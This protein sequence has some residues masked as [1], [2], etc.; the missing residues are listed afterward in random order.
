M[1]GDAEGKTSAESLWQLT[2]AC[3]EEKAFVENVDGSVQG[4]FYRPLLKVAKRYRLYGKIH[5]WLPLAYMKYLLRR[6]RIPILS[7]DL[8]RATNNKFTGGHLVVVLSYNGPTDTFQIHDTSSVLAPSGDAL[9]LKASTLKFISN[10]R[11]LSF[12]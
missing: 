4:I 10:T 8:S 1:V 6:N 11:G 12:S 2:Q 7:I 5:R 3:I 9:A